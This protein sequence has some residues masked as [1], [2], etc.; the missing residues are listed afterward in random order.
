MN[1]GPT[2]NIGISAIATYQPPWLLGNDWFEGTIPRKFVHHTG[3]KSRPI[4][5]EDEVTMAIRAAKALQ[6]EVGCDWRNCAGVVFCSP[7]FIPLPVARKYFDDRRARRERL[8]PAARRFARRMN[9]PECPIYAIN[10]FCSGYARALAIAQHRIAREINLSANQFILVIN[11]SRISRITDFSCR[12]TGALFGDMATATLLAREDSTLH[13]PH[14]ALL[15]A[16]AH[17][18]PADSAYFH[19]HL[20]QHVLVPQRD[21]GRDYAPERVVFSLDGM[22]VA[23][24]AP[25]AMSQGIVE[26]LAATGI[27]PADIRFVVPHQAGTGIIRLAAMK[28]EALGISGEVIN[29]MTSEVGNV[30]SCSIPYTLL[31]NWNRLDSIIACPTA[32]VGRPGY[33]EMSQGC[34]LLQATPL[35][36]KLA[37]AA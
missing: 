16:A 13:P 37:T 4:S 8:R 18:Q 26:A 31:K 7:S 12:Q 1:T 11:T 29:G 36:T 2:E 23:D 5:E 30:S 28:I 22:G 24:S 10:W 6:R 25:R 15:Y 3:I 9:L 34:V 19:F 14:F 27:S 33:C 17:K 20:R 21:G 32:A 35:H